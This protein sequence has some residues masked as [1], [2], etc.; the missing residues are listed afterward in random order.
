MRV[1]VLAI[2]WGALDLDAP[3]DILGHVARPRQSEPHPS[4]IKGAGAPHVTLE[5]TWGRG[6]GR[7]SLLSALR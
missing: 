4:R 5:T 3:L 6:R 1:K 2:S 7:A